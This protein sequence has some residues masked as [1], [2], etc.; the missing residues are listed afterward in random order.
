MNANLQ[1]F[2]SQNEP[3]PVTALEALNKSEID[4][5]IATAHRFPRSLLKFKNEALAM[6]TLDEETASSCFYALKRKSAD[7]DGKTIE[8]PSIRLAE[9]I[10][11]AWGNLRYGARIVETGDR[12]V[13][14]QGVCHD[15]EKNIC[16]NVEVRRRITGRDGR[17]YSDDMIGVTCN[18]ACSIA[19]RNAIFKV[20]P[21][22]YAKDIY[23]KAKKVAVGDAQTLS[24]RRQQMVQH[25]SKMGVSV[26]QI[27]A[28]LEKPS[29][30]DIGLEDLATLKGVATA[31][32]DGETTIDQEFP[33]AA[34]QA[35]KERDRPASQ[36]LSD[37]LKKSKAVKE[38]EALRNQII[39]RLLST[40][41]NDAGMNAALKAASLS[42]DGHKWIELDNLKDCEDVAQLKGILSKLQSQESNASKESSDRILNPQQTAF[43]ERTGD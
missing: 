22:A 39:Q 24:T 13:T 11:S 15:L 20:V 7:G 17:R 29:I 14:A 41:S 21:M 25:F 40:G 9:I 28:H 38:A 33:S 6:A 27:L 35:N 10:G 5:Q 42:G 8:G 31:I 1:I 2:D 12:F 43:G 4:T 36:R 37:H 26:E 18:A 23:E 19:L 16:A 32:K 34:S 30:E 3:Q